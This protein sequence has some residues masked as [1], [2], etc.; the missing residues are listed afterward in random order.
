MQATKYPRYHQSF[1]DIDDFSE[2]VWGWD[3]NFRLLDRT[4]FHADAQ[5]VNTE[6]I[7]LS[8][9]RF[10]AA[11]EQRGE[12]PHMM[13]TF[14]VLNT[15]SPDIVWRG[16]RVSA[17]MLMIYPP[18]SEID[19]VS[20]AGF[21]VLTISVSIK[22][23]EGWDSIYLMADMPRIRPLCTA[24]KIEPIKLNAIR[25]AANNTINTAVFKTPIQ[26]SANQEL[27]D[28]LFEALPVAIP[29]RPKPSLNKKTHLMKKL[30]GYINDH[31]DESITLTEMC[32][33]AKVS[34]RT[35]QRMFKAHFGLS[36]KGYIRARRLNEVR[37]AIQKNKGSCNEKISDI[38][39]RWGFW[40]MGQFA[41]DYKLFFGELPSQTLGT[42]KN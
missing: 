24:A 25:I 4:G 17:D 22:V 2:S 33:V 21:D 1:N 40:H 23:F 16:Q 10:N 42:L 19:A 38:A 26:H 29:R 36:P 5:Q 8:R 14:A 31:I 6:T 27:T 12:S 9:G 3:L 18:G 7:L 30:T 32:A 11:L 37:H 34:P 20:P 41:S 15:S 39:N 13:W 28:L 35:I